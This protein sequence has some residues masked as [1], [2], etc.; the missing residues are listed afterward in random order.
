MNENP[1]DKVIESGSPFDEELVAYLDGELDAESARRIEALLA[2]D[3]VV[4]RRL[5][6]LERT[7]D[8]LDELDAAP[9]GEPFT[10]TTLEMVAVAARQEVEQSRAAAPRRRRRWL[11]AVGV[12]LLLTA[13][14]GFAAVAMYDPD[15]QL[16]ED[17]PLLEN[18]DEYHQIGTIE[19]LHRLRDEKF[20]VTAS[21]KG[22][23]SVEES[24]GSRR[25]RVEGMSPAAREQLL[26]AEDRFLSS[27]LAEQQRLRRL[28]EDL[29]DDPDSEQ[30]RAIMHA[31]HE[32]LKPLPAVMW[33]ELGEGETN[34]R[35]ALV[36]KRLQ[37]QQRAGAWQPDARTMA[38]LRSWM[39]DC[40]TRH[41]A[42]FQKLLPSDQERKRFT[43]AGKALR[44]QMVAG[45]LRWQ[46]MRPSPGK[47]PLLMTADD[48]SR[49]CE[50]LRPEAKKQL[51]GK[52]P[53]QQWRTVTAWMR[54][55]S[56]RQFEDRRPH[57]RL[58]QNDDERLVE[59]FEKGLTV[60]ERDRLLAM[61]S[62]EMQWELQRLFLMHNRP[63]EGPDRRNRRPGEP[64]W[65]GPAWPG[66]GWPGPGP[67][68][69]SSTEK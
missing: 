47:L 3:T 26:L 63:P 36:K 65:S 15:R 61:P 66:P 34:E 35:I 69:P 21:V 43:Q 68:P 24:V 5:Q 52:A 57:G 4:R 55:S 11:L 18:L 10:Q 30:L 54:Q 27:P 9:L 46:W 28:Y 45:F 62:E 31:Y 19:F 12:S 58:S 53:A 13:A 33:A 22:S 2:S 60:E 56:R 40:A 67:T 23:A 17:L 42:D 37:E 7:W 39:D 20:P 14:A 48:L 16:L 59:F 1:P 29:R 32:W 38:A 6:S 51:E 50:K 44:H 49:L 8:L 41:E 25:Q 64:G